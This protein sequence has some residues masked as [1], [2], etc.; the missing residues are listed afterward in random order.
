M[1]SRLEKIVA[2]II[3]LLVVGY[4]SINFI[5]KLPLFLIGENIA[6]AI[7]YSTSIYLTLKKWRWY[8]LYLLSLSGVNLG[9]VSRSVITPQGTPA[10]LALQHI[11][12]LAY[13][14]LVFILAI[15]LAYREYK[16]K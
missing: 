16:E 13:I 5:V 11:P 14:A 9:R 10:K 12:L 8:P 6:L 4:I 2:V 1:A 7:L 3:G 15:I